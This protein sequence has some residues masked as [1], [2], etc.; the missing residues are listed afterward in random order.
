MYPDAK[1]LLNVRDPIKWYQ[2]V[3]DSILQESHSSN[4]CSFATWGGASDANPKGD[5][6]TNHF[7]SIL[8]I[9]WSKY[10]TLGHAPGSLP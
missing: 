10:R 5:I 6:S 7:K 1:V 8:C 3:R 4:V 2:S 9:R